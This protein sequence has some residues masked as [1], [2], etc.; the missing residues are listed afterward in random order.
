MAPTTVTPE[1]VKRMDA[2]EVEGVHALD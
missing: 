2:I 1:L